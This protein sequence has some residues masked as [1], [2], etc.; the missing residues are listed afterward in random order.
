MGV[1]NLSRIVSVVIVTFAFA[2]G[3]CDG[4]PSTLT[5]VAI[6]SKKIAE[7]SQILPNMAVTS[8]EK[9]GM[10]QK[11]INS[12]M[13]AYPTSKV[14]QRKELT[15]IKTNT[16]FFDVLGGLNRVKAILFK[17]IDVLIKNANTPAIKQQLGFLKTVFKENVIPIK[18][19]EDSLNKIIAMEQ[20]AFQ[21]YVK[22]LGMG[23]RPLHGKFNIDAELELI[24]IATNYL[25]RVKFDPKLGKYGPSSIILI[26]ARPD[27][28]IKMQ[29]VLMRLD[30]YIR[31]AEPKSGE[32][33]L[34][35]FI[36]KNCETL[37][38][39]DDGC[40]FV[41]CHDAPTKELN[42]LINAQK[43]GYAWLEI[44]VANDC[45]NKKFTQSEKHEC[46]GGVETS[47][48]TREMNKVLATQQ[49]TFKAELKK[50]E[51]GKKLCLCKV[52]EIH[53]HERHHKEG[54]DHKDDEKHGSAKKKHG[55]AKEKHDDDKEK[56]DKAKG[57]HSED[58]K[59]IT[60]PPRRTQPTRGPRRKPANPGVGR[61]R[62][63]AAGHG[64]K[65]GE[66]QGAGE[67][68]VATGKRVS[69]KH[70]KADGKREFVEFFCKPCGDNEFS[71]N[72]GATK[73]LPCPAILDVN[74]LNHEQ[75]IWKRIHQYEKTKQKRDFD[76]EVLK[77]R[78]TDK[79]FKL[80]HNLRYQ[81]IN[82]DKEINA[83]LSCCANIFGG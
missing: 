27:N 47:S 63:D 62:R 65:A 34:C 81:K 40:T 60:R 16:K 79:I 54:E 67:K 58:K 68:Q 14:A 38:K 24:E 32:S 26:H 66:K 29:N 8:F 23:S 30:Q 13:D 72:P 49:E 53:V 17:E 36:S 41:D 52:G 39:K 9:L 5:V 44:I 21:D 59:G 10:L 69:N 57:T 35:S 56:H 55:A 25:K 3:R 75:C 2:L 73:C 43:A 82:H 15:K 33:L 37:R 48:V 19:F 76:Y 4:D 83:A 1:P 18:Y 6:S 50:K 71:L 7:V 78:S 77:H 42:Y 51:K 70:H 11:A 31:Y 22:S 80:E 61:R 45:Q 20:K 28:L 74:N 64:H 46:L 12:I